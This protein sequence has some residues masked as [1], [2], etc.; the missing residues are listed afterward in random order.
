MIGLSVRRQ[1]NKLFRTHSIACDF[2]EVKLNEFGE[3]DGE[4]LI[5]SYSG[6]FYKDKSNRMINIK[7]NDKGQT[8]NDDFYTLMILKDDKTEILND[9]MTCSIDN[10]RYEI[11][12]I[13]NE[14]DIYFVF[15][16]KLIVGE[17]NES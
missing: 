4:E 9:K 7:I 16:L 11:I 8:L 6:I 5:G 3:E 15:K 13:D 14:L 17:N 1:I 12:T 10:K 2:F